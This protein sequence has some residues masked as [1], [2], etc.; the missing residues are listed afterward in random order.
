MKCGFGNITDFLFAAAVLCAFDVD[1]V[2]DVLLPDPSAIDRKEDI[3]L[4]SQHSLTPIK[5]F[6][7]ETN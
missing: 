4:T 5:N 2:V 3:L 1:A 7:C 6:I